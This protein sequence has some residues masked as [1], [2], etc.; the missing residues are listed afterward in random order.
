MAVK[1]SVNVE[2]NGNAAFEEDAAA[3]E[4][5]RILRDVALR[6]ENQDYPDG[7]VPIRDINGNKCGSFFVEDDGE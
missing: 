7:E 5:A 3:S 2:T 1:I 6:I 4:I